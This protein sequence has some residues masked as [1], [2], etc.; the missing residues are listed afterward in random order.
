VR[1]EFRPLM[2]GDVPLFFEWLQRPHVREWWDSERTIEEVYANYF[3]PDAVRQ[4]KA[5]I[6][7]RDGKPFAYIQSYLAIDANDGWWEGQHDASV[8]GMDLFLANE[9]D[10]GRGLGTE[11]VK[12]FAEKLFAE[13]ITKIQIDPSP[14][15]P[16]AIRCYEKAGFVR[17]REIVTPDGPALLMT[18]SPISDRA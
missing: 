6:A 1:I 4:A 18:L 11:L 9:N 15:N 8:A 3:P 12:E 16:R 17:Q 14:E 5:Y 2:E 7:T 10:R 13:G